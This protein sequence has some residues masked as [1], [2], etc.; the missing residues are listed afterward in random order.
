MNCFSWC[1]YYELVLDVVIRLKIQVALL[2]LKFIR[3]MF[4]RLILVCIRILLFV[5]VVIHCDSMVFCCLFG[6]L[7][8]LV[9]QNDT[10]DSFCNNNSDSVDC[11]VFWWSRTIQ[12]WYWL[13]CS[14]VTIFISNLLIV[15]DGFDI[16]MVNDDLLI[17]IF[18]NLLIIWWLINIIIW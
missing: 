14:V 10:V 16:V 11:C 7:C 17:I 8:L 18:G 15:F 4:I 5:T 1:W 9:I 2:M 13:Y 3:F 6:L 12:L